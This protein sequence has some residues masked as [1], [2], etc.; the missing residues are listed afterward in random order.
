MSNDNNL[1]DDCKSV[2]KCVCILKE[3][4][5]PICNLPFQQ[6]PYTAM[7]WCKNTT[8]ELGRECGHDRACHT[9]S[10]AQAIDAAISVMQKDAALIA[11]LMALN[12]ELNAI[13]SQCAKSVGAI[14]LPECSIEFKRLLPNEIS[15]A[16]KSQSSMADE[17]A[18]TLSTVL[19]AIK[20]ERSLALMSKWLDLCVHID[21]KLAKHRSMK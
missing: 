19:F 7:E 13:I 11:E 16:V 10:D 21:N 1:M 2:E 20:G 4:K 12:G 8:N 15:A 3:L 9:V 5:R 17:L 14:A 18:G 6:C